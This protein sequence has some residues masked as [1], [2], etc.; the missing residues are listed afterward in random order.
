MNAQ[1]MRSF[2]ERPPLE[3]CQFPRRMIERVVIARAAVLSPRAAG[4]RPPSP[5]LVRQRD[6]AVPLLQSSRGRF[7]FIERIFTATA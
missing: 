3:Q 4:A 7:H 1:L 6:G 5:P 2:G